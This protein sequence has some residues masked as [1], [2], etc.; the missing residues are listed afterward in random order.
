M[1][2]VRRLGIEARKAIIA[3]L[4]YDQTVYSASGGR[5]SWQDHPT[6]AIASERPGCFSFEPGAKWHGFE[7]YAPAI[8]TLSIRASYCPEGNHAE[9]SMLKPGIY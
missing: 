2:G 5:P 1:G 9:A 3:E 7:G 4:P 6:Q 8:S